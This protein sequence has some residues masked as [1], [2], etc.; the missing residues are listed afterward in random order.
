M[1][2]YHNFNTENMKLILVLAI[3]VLGLT[4]GRFFKNRHRGPECDSGWYRVM[5]SCIWLSREKKNFDDARDHCATMNLDQ[6][7]LFEPTSRLQ[8]DLV[9]TLLKNRQNESHAWIGITDRLEEGTFRYLSSGK[10]VFFTKWTIG[11]PNN[12][13]PGDDGSQNCVNI[14][15]DNDESWDDLMCDEEIHYICE[16]LLK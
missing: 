14:W 3:T 15:W 4:Q 16:D 1:I 13:G 6:G 9:V 7:R 12:N 11:E 5:E 2:N 10:E 8:N